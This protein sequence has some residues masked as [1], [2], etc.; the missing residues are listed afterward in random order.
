MGVILRLVFV[1]VGALG[2]VFVG[3]NAAD[4]MGLVKSAD[5]LAKLGPTPGGIAANISTQVGNGLEALGGMIAKAQG[6]DMSAPDAKPGILVQ[7][8]PEVI[9]A[10]VSALMMMFGMRR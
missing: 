3:L 1:V 8:G 6:V 5:L 4:Q 7:Y 10:V 9:G 2:L